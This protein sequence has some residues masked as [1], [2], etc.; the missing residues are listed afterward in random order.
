MT[1]PDVDRRSGLR[2]PAAPRKS[3][4]TG[5]YDAAGTLEA[6]K[7]D[8]LPNANTVEDVFRAAGE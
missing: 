7:I 6:L 4:K 8:R 3:L 5:Q 2:T 1:L